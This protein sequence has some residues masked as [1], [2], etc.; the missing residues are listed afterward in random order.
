MLQLHWTQ[1]S[2][3][4]PQ[5]LHLSSYP[6]ST[7]PAWVMALQ[8]PWQRLLWSLSHSES[9]LRSH[10]DTQLHHHVLH[11]H[12]RRLTHWLLLLPLRGVQVNGCLSSVRRTRKQAVGKKKNTRVSL[13]A[14]FNCQHLICTCYFNCYLMVS[15]ADVRAHC[16]V[17][18]TL[19]IVFFLKS[20]MDQTSIMLTSFALSEITVI[21]L[22]TLWQQGF[23]R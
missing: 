10:P 3:C 1:R 18:N 4:V 2:A 8:G 14:A 16:V 9:S 23:N 22:L 11:T 13:Q 7:G 21:R 20:G 17:N 12:K 19:L 5:A 6:D 15:H